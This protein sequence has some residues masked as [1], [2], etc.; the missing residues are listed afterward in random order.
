MQVC[1]QVPFIVHEK[2]CEKVCVEPKGYLHHNKKGL[3][4]LAQ[5]A[6]AAA[7]A[8]HDFDGFDHQDYHVAP[9]AGK[10]KGHVPIHVPAPICHDVRKGI[11]CLCD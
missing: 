1:I 11:V 2:R 6:A 10:G 8:G 9:S 5:Y 4:R 7:A 3:R